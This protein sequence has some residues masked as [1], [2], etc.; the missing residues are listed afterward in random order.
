MGQFAVHLLP[1]RRQVL[2]GREWERGK[3]LYIRWHTNE[4]MRACMF[5]WA[6]ICL[7]S[8]LFIFALVLELNYSQNAAADISTIKN[9]LKPNSLSFWNVKTNVTISTTTITANNNNSNSTKVWKKWHYNTI[10]YNKFDWHK[11]KLK[12]LWIHLFMPVTP[13]QMGNWA[14]YSI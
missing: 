5:G 1:A 12:W 10:L 6:Y 8:Q 9:L 4:W 11:L 2:G 14:Y 13:I 3:Y 7:K